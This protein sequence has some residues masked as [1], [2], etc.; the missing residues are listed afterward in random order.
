MS[1]TEA[2]V[3]VLPDC[4]FRPCENK[5]EYDFRTLD[6]RWAFGCEADYLANRMY[7]TLGMGKGQRLISDIMVAQ[8]AA[9]SE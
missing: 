7:E 5:A 3:S 2:R 1:D 6:G 8:E 9:T 4:N